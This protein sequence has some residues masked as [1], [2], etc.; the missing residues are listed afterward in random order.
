MHLLRMLMSAAAVVELKCV[1]SL[2]WVDEG[3]FSPFRS[4]FLGME[5]LVTFS[6]TE[7]E[8]RDFFFWRTFMSSFL[9]LRELFSWT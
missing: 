2:F 6:S 3:S 5:Q 7:G 9:L 8:K 1:S 4:L